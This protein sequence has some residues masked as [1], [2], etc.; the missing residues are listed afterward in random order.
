M[1]ASK[2]FT[3]YRALGYVSNHVPLVTRYQEKVKE[4]YVITCV[5][6]AFHT[7]NCSKL[8]ISNISDTHPDEISC[9]AANHHQVF[10]ACKNII[11]CFL[12]GQQ[13]IRKYIGHKSA[14]HILLTFAAH[15]ISVDEDSFVRIWNIKNKELYLEMSFDNKQF[16]VTS[17]VHPVT[18]LNKVLFG[19]AQGTLQLWNLKSNKLIYTFPGWNSKVTVLEQAPAVD[20]IAVGLEDGR[21]IVHNIRYDESVMKFAQ[22]WAPVTTISFRSD[23]HPIMVSGS[24]SGHMAVWDLEENRIKC[25]VRD[26][27]RSS[28]TGMYCLPSE[29]LMVTS[30]GDNTL[31]VWIFDMPDG[32]PRLLRKREGHSS[33]PLK[34]RYYGENGENILSAGLDSTLRSFSL[35]HDKYNKSLGQASYYKKKSKREK[36]KDKYVMS[37][38][39]D[40]AAE[41]RRESDWDNI[42]ACHRGSHLVTTWSYLRSTM[43]DR[44]FDVYKQRKEA[45]DGTDIT[46]TSVGITSCGNYCLLGYSSGHVDVFNIQSGIYRGSYGEERCHDGA[47]H[48]I[49]VDANNQITVTAGADGTLKF[50][51][52]KSKQLLKELK[53]DSYISKILLHRES[54]LLAVSLNNLSVSIVDLQTKNVIRVFSD[55]QHQITDMTFSPD[56]RWLITSSMDSL[57]RTWD[58]PSGRLIDCFEVDTPVSSV[59][60]SPTGI[61]LATSHIDDI[62]IYLWSNKSLYQQTSLSA[63]SDDFVPKLISAPTT[64]YAAEASSFSEDEDEEPIDDDDESPFKS[65]DQISNE[66]ITLSLMPNSRWKNLLNLDII[67]L[68]NKPKQPPKK[69]KAA[70][71]FLPTI[72]G[73]D[74]KFAVEKEKNQET[75]SRI[76]VGL[77]THLSETGKL[78]QNANNEDDY[79]K[80][81]DAF[82]EMGP[83][84]I[85]LEIRGFG[86]EDGGSEILMYQFLKFIE[87]LLD[88]RKNY[89]LAQSYLG[90]FL[91]IHFTEIG[92]NVKLCEL[93]KQLHQQHVQVWHELQRQFAQTNCLIDY[94]RAA[95][96]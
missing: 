46:A 67:R 84:A 8:G 49:A 92:T 21:I 75:T 89:E 30:S 1:S 63:L 56:A 91:Q 40:F 20:V 14:V 25:Q 27:H 94:L 19:S 39:F 42:V 51:K 80:I 59:S 48:G 35:V 57:V 76:S 52:F 6:K 18:Y 17:A 65:P 7:Y 13:V 61:F 87:Y 93:I 31:K 45:K 22:T 43:G 34:I 36:L 86:V 88:S 90:L 83:S 29:P 72:P 81:L 74:I 16:Q 15:L 62:G 41:V 12:R 33:P 44:K 38:I 55:H 73:N 64:G 82:K 50:W 5:G 53:L 24:A 78:L 54:S 10:T 70:P 47:V 11:Y 85:D 23:G 95:N 4:H 77:K 69:P 9:L 58:L 71:F 2:I 3:G 66:L 32:S 26:A 79:L 68:R 96:Y 60:M 28:I 37:P